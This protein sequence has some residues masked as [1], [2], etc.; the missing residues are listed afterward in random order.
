MTPTPPATLQVDVD[1]IWNYLADLGVNEAGDPSVM[2]QESIERFLDLFSSFKVK[3]TFFCIGRDLLHPRVRALVRR[4]VREG[5]EVAN[6]SFSHVQNFSALSRAELHTEIVSAHTLLERATGKRVLGFKAPGWCINAHT[7][8]ILHELGY[9]YDSSYLPSFVSP[10]LSFARFV[11]SGGVRTQK[12]V[13]SL[14]TSFGPLHPHYPAVP[15]HALDSR[16]LSQSV[17]EIPQS[18]FP[19]IRFPFHSTFVFLLGKVYFRQGLAW[20]KRTRLPLNYVFHALDLLP[21]NLE[22]RLAKFPAM[23]QTLAARQ[24][25]LR[26]ILGQIT[27]AYRV[28]TTAALAKLYAHPARP[29]APGAQQRS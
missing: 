4:L 9:T 20:M 21:E 11:L 29:G 23:R 3:A 10:L 2:Y 8:P 12:K 14:K 25:T 26:G 17:L 24:Q 22:P 18:V 7:L 6:H 19:G 16:P 28:Q 5:H 13:G 27:D 15:Y 1:N